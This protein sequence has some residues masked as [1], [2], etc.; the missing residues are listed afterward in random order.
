MQSRKLSD[1]QQAFLDA[2]LEQFSDIPENDSAID[3][4][5]SPAFQ[6]KAQE[7]LRKSNK[8][9]FSTGKTVLRRIALVAIIAAMLALTAC[10]IPAVREAII[11]FFFRDAG[12]HYAFTYDPEQAATAPDSLETVY[13]PTYV[14]DG[15]ELVV[16][17]ISAVGATLMWRNSN[18]VWINYVQSIMPDDPTLGDGGGFNSEGAETEWI[19]LNGCNVLRIV[20]DEWIH[21]VWTSS[22]YRFSIS[23]DDK[24]MEEVVKKVFDS[25]QIDSDAVIAGIE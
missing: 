23:T 7:L 6:A 13:T 22:E 8:N 9:Y 20:D 24:S 3:F 14:A 15:F 5:F 25:I 17:D 18:E 16:E 12:D 19:A 11:D 10:A 21:F 2:K 1:L 4:E